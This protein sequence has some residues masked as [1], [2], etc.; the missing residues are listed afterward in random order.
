MGPDQVEQRLY[1]RAQY[2]VNQVAC[3]HLTLP[4]PLPLPYPY[5]YPYRYPYPYSYS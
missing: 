5:P 2:V 4:L 1:L 3:A